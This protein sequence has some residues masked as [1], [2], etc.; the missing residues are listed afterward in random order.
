VYGFLGHA[1]RLTSQ[2]RDGIAQVGRTRFES[3][4]YAGIVDAIGTA[5]IRPHDLEIVDDAAEASFTAK[6][7]HVVKLG[8]T[9]RIEASDL[10][11]DKPLEVEVPRE[12]FDELHIEVGSNVFLAVRRV[13]VFVDESTRKVETA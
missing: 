1:N 8:S 9:V 12:R 7:E 11:D 3:P 2:V 10:T 6:V 4:D 13:R 5:F